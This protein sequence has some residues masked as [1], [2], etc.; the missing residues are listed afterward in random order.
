MKYVWKQKEE[1]LWLVATA[2]G[3]VALQAMATFDPTTITDYKA[4]AA[5]I[6]AAAVRA[7]GG[8]LLSLVTKSP[9][10]SEPE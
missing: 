7:A 5:G 9:P 6:G 1:A 8:A 2:V 4:W 3:V 10:S